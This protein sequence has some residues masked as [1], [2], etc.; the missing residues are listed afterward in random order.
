MV[1]F[2]PFEPIVFCLSVHLKTSCYCVFS[3]NFAMFFN[4]NKNINNLCPFVFEKKILFWGLR[5]DF[6]KF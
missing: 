3:I 4:N 6:A 2:L 5:T 1:H